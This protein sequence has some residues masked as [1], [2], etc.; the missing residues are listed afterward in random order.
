MNR[1][2]TF[3]R[4]KVVRRFKLRDSDAARETFHKTLPVSVCYRK[5]V[6]S[7]LAPSGNERL[8]CELPVLRELTCLGCDIA[9]GVIIRTAVEITSAR[10]RRVETVWLMDAGFH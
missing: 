4:S 8:L 5:V 10:R 9:H 7:Q 3:K 1:L 2:V 6:W